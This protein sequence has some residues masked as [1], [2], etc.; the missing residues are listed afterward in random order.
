MYLEEVKNK[1]KYKPMNTG[2]CTYVLCMRN[3]RVRD[4]NTCVRCGCPVSRKEITY[5]AA[6]DKFEKILEQNQFALN[7]HIFSD[8]EM[9]SLKIPVQIGTGNKDYFFVPLRYFV[10]FQNIKHSEDYKDDKK[11]IVEFI[12]HIM[13]VSPKVRL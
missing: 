9:N 5:D 2:F 3:V 10:E 8:V 13:A 7:N 6:M 11:S 4:D 12:E 1:A